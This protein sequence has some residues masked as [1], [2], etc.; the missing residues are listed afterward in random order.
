MKW[1]AN[2]K[3]DQVEVILP[4]QFFAQAGGREPD[5]LPQLLAAVP[6]TVEEQLGAA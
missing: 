3:I 6:K 1:L 4:G 5:K 2:Y